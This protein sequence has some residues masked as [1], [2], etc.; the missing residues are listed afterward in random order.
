MILITELGALALW[1]EQSGT[2]RKKRSEEAPTACE[3]GTEDHILC[4]N[5][6]RLITTPEERISIDGAH[7]HDFV[8][9]H[10]LV[11]GIGCFGAAPGCV[12]VG[13]MTTDWTWFPGFGWSIA[14][15]RSWVARTRA[16]CGSTRRASIPVNWTTLVRLP[17]WFA[18][19]QLLG[20]RIIVPVIV[21]G[22]FR[23]AAGRRPLPLKMGP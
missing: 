20:S 14:I 5:C 15:C 19:V 21:R 10:G 4:A 16:V 2:Q 7:E 3:T 12:P 9:P 13:E 8:N 11:F 1:F 17:F 18:M 23:L 6:R 22:G